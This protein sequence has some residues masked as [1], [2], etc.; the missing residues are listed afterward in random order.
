MVRSMKLFNLVNDIM[1]RSGNM[2]MLKASRVWIAAGLLLL[3]GCASTDVTSLQAYRG[4]R[5][6]RPG[7]IVVYDFATTPAD[8]PP[9]LPYEAAAIGITSAARTNPPTP[10]EVATVRKLGTLVAQ[11][12][13]KNLRAMGLPAVEGTA[14]AMPPA[15]LQPDDIALAGYFA[16]VDPG[17][18]AKRLMIGF[19][20][21][22]PELNTVIEGYQ[23]TP[24]GTLLRLGGGTVDAGGTKVPGM[25]V[26]LAVVA[27]N[28]NPIGL[29]VN[30]AIKVHGEESGSATI[31]G[32]AKRTADKIAEQMRPTIERQGWT[33]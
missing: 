16:T 28:G 15:S 27:A 26:P 29:I 21:G 2:D 1:I 14:A 5:L 32:A 8:L 17:S 11:E 20:S 4:E 3:T 9:G 10:A 23:M 13:V 33:A 22:A 24:Q 25:L 18:E 6:P 12:L 30:G 7:K 19:G 31:E